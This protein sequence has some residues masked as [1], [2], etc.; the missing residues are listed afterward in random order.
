M[1]EKLPHVRIGI[2]TSSTN[3]EMPIGSDEL[4]YCYRDLTGSIMNNGIEVKSKF[5]HP[6]TIGDTIGLLI[7]MNPP[8]PP[9]YR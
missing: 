6:Y 5:G 8:L 3:L 9:F 7:Y 4:S 1:D 2:T